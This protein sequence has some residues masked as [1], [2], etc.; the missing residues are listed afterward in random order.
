MKY[1]DQ[2]PG[3]VSWSSEEIVIPYLKPT[4]GQKHRYFPD[5]KIDVRTATGGLKTFLIEIK[6][7]AETKA[8]KPRGRKTKKFLN[9][10]MTYAVNQA[11]WAAANQFCADRGWTFLVL[12]EDHLSIRKHGPHCKCDVCYENF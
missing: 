7:K 5:F 11:K 1:C 8:P 10:A 4:D 6:P 2:T 9:E 3:V 12:T